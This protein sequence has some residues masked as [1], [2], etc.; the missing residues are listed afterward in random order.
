MDLPCIEDNWIYMGLG[1]LS[2]KNAKKLAIYWIQITYAVLLVVLAMEVKKKTSANLCL[3]H[4]EKDG[5]LF[6][7]CLKSMDNYYYIPPEK[8]GTPH[9]LAG[10][11]D[12]EFFC[13]H[14][15]EGSLNYRITSV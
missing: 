4:L 6:L 2:S 11:R 1:K 15:G 7:F 3:S 13:S 5:S 12:P 14:F 8:H 9:T 10:P